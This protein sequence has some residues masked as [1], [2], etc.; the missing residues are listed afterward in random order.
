MRILFWL[1]LTF[2]FSVFEIFIPS[3]I[4]I[5]F[6]LA[7]FLTIGITFFFEN[8]K[9]EIL[10]FFISS[11]FF[12]LFTRPYAKKFLF[13]NNEKFDSSMIGS[14]I[15]VVKIIDSQK[16]EKIYEVKFKGAIWTA[17]SKDIFAVGES[18]VISEF[19]GNKIIIKK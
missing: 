7:A 6:A 4:T 18:A 3:L 1:A 10:F 12:I 13:K 8:L 11:V 9:I 15:L 16:E 17:L 2:L 5:W 19:K 14:Q